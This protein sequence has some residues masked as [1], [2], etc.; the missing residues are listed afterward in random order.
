MAKVKMKGLLIAVGKMQVFP[1]KSG[2][3]E[4]KVV[5]LHFMEPGRIDEFG[6]KVGEDQTFEIRVMNSRIE[7]L[8]PVILDF[9]KNPIDEIMNIME[10]PKAIIEA[11]INSRLVETDSKSFYALELSMDKCELV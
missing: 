1:N 10:K 9:V 7:K 6:E 4:T 3:G 5:K 2:V 8:P 11:Y